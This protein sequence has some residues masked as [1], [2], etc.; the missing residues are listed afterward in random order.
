MYLYLMYKIHANLLCIHNVIQE[1]YG[2]LANLQLVSKWKSTQC[3][4][5]GSVTMSF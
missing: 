4:L 1:Q 2:D 5:C 3:N